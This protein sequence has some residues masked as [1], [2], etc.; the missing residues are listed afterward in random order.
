VTRVVFDAVA[1]TDLLQ[2][3]H[4]IARAHLKPLR[5]K[6]FVLRLEIRKLLLQLFFDGLYGVLQSRRRGNEVLRRIQDNPIHTIQNAT[7]HWV[8]ER[9]RFD[10]VSEPFDAHGFLTIGGKNL[11]RIAPDPERSAAEGYVVAHVL[12]MYQT[13]HDFVTID[14]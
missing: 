9:K 6:Q 10:L 3:L 12:D 5:L 11:K 14:G 7:R 4:I 8:D 1:V 13:T 2:H